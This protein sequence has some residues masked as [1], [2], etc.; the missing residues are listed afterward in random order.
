LVVGFGVFVILNTWRRG[1]IILS[2]RG[3]ADG[4][5][6]DD[7]VAQLAAEPIHRVP[8]TALFM[9]HPNSMPRSLLHHVKHNKVLHER[10]ILMSVVTEEVPTVPESRQVTFRELPGGFTKIQAH[11][12]FMQSVNV[13]HLLKLG[14]SQ[15]L[16]L[17]RG[18]ISYYVGRMTLK[19]TG[20]TKLM[21]WQKRLFVFL[22]H[23]ERSPADHFGLPANRVIEL[24]QQSEI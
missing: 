5:T 8:G 18:E 11:C 16:K 19:T 7:V 4:L 17:P 1:K 6:V 23:N 15:G 13:P 21:Q 10:V 9:I 20:R 14:E 12:G 2:R 22:F 24:G 3:Q